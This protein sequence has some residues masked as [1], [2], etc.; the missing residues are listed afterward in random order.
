MNE[1]LKWLSTNPIVATAVAA[2]F[3]IFLTSATLVYLIAFFKVVKYLFGRQ[4]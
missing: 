4:R 2:S 3:A 1:F